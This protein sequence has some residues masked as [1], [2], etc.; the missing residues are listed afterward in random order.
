MP[1]LLKVI[2]QP[3]LAE[4]SI[5]TTVIL[6]PTLGMFLRLKRTKSELGQPVAAAIKVVERMSAAI[7]DTILKRINF[8]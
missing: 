4:A 7:V 2:I 3:S 1:P 6:C 8:M 5:P